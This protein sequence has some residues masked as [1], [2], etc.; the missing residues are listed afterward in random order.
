MKVQ[1]LPKK[2]GS[3]VDA[4]FVGTGINQIRLKNKI[5]WTYVEK[6]TGLGDCFHLI[7]VQS[8]LFSL[9]WL[10]IKTNKWNKRRRCDFYRRWIHNWSYYVGNI[11]RTRISGRFAL[12]VITAFH[13][14]TTELFII[15]G[16]CLQL[17]ILYIPASFVLFMQY[18]P[19]L[20]AAPVQ[21]SNLIYIA[22]VH[23]LFIWWIKLTFQIHPNT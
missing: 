13:F 23:H 18:Q 2:V 6:P 12:T 7:S 19:Q 21:L 14:E 15:D 17:W 10:N 11:H 4:V 9:V 16:S 22:D 5:M 3:W 1:V 20:K 8:M